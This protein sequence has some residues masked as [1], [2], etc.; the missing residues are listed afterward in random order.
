MR[1]RLYV[2]LA[3]AS[4]VLLMAGGAITLT[5]NGTAGT[6]GSVETAVSAQGQDTAETGWL[7][8]GFGALL[9]AAG[10]FWAY[11]RLRGKRAS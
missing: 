3:V 10:S 7:L 2:L 4:G 9:A 5:D 6:A 1:E 11:S 8:L